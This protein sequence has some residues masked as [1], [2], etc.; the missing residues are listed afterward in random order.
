MIWLSVAPQRPP[1][2]RVIMDVRDK[3]NDQL[4]RDR[5]SAADPEVFD[6]VNEYYLPAMSDW[7]SKYPDV[8]DPADQ[9]A[10]DALDAFFS[11][12]ETRIEEDDQ[13]N[14]ETA[15][16]VE[17]YMRKAVWS[18]A[19]ESRRTLLGRRQKEIQLDIESSKG[20]GGAIR[21]PVSS[22]D[23]TD[24]IE[25]RIRW[26][27]AFTLLKQEDQDIIAEIL[28]TEAKANPA[29]KFARIRNSGITHNASGAHERCC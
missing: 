20:A 12:I 23:L 26:A 17:M 3:L 14:F 1:I 16:A 9:I 4:Y 8:G 25:T 5:L 6:E 19:M 2:R 29:G 7:A 18:K 15:A 13:I 10:R 28:G 27:R 11:A 24:V 22:Q 21:E